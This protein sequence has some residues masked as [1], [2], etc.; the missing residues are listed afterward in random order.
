LSMMIYV[1]MILLDN[2]LQYLIFIVMIDLSSTHDNTSILICK[3]LV[4][5]ELCLD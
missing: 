1:G 2:L 3:S 4:M 5:F